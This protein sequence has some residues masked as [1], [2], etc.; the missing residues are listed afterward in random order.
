MTKETM[1]YNGKTID[2]DMDKECN[3]CSEKGATRSGLCL[4]CLAESMTDRTIG[5]KVIQQAKAEICA[6][7]EEYAEDIDKAYLQAD[8]DL[9]VPFTV[10]LKPTRIAG[11]IELIVGTNFVK[12]RI[13]HK[14]KVVV[15]SKQRPLPG[16]ERS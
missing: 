1:S 15:D 5:F 10:Q 9:T 6:M 16:F 13:K 3:R 12:D 11:E 4:K 7:L 2:I 8:N 14:I